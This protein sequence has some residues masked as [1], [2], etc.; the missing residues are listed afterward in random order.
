[1][2][3]K[4]TKTT[5]IIKT[6][7]DFRKIVVDQN[8]DAYENFMDAALQG[9]L[10][11]ASTDAKHA[12]RRRVVAWWIRN[13]DDGAMDGWFTPSIS[14]DKKTAYNFN[15][16]YA[17][18]IFQKDGAAIGVIGI[19]VV[20]KEY[21]GNIMEGSLHKIRNVENET[22]WNQAINMLAAMID[23]DEAPYSKETEEYIGSCIIDMDINY[24]RNV[25]DEW[26]DSTAEMDVVA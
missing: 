15:C 14:I 20:P 17:P 26:D 12:L 1:M 9:H 7:A 10:R 6:P 21:A 23:K 8:W 2:E 5:I 4:I 11:K 24:L 18:E 25:E 16:Q 3:S 19:S 22:E 13:T